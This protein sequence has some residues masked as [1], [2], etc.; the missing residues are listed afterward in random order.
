MKAI[1]I[2][3]HFHLTSLIFYLLTATAASSASVALAGGDSAPLT[4]G[5][6]VVARCNLSAVDTTTDRAAATAPD[7]LLSIECAQKVTPLVRVNYNSSGFS[8]TEF[9]PS[10]SGIRA[11]S[12]RISS[13]S[14][15]LPKTDEGSYTG[16]L[17]VTVNF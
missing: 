15:S 17:T 14:T 9:N 7:A 1:A 2:R 3:A 5:A 16:N 13:M 10:T 6:T 8:E 4:I 12:D 11:Q